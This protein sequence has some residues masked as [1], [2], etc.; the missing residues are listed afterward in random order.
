MLVSCYIAIISLVLLLPSNEKFIYT[1]NAFD[2]MC[3]CKI[4]SW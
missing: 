3:I 4:S 2:G 1:Y